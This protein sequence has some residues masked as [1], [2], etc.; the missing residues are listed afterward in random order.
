MLHRM[1]WFVSKQNFDFLGF[2][3]NVSHFKYGIFCPF[4][5]LQIQKGASKESIMELFSSVKK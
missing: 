3:L 5:V 2:S 4:K 1:L